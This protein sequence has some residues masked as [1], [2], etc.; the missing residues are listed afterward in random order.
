MHLYEPDVEKAISAIEAM[1][2]AYPDKTLWLTEFGPY[3]GGPSGCHFDQAGVVNYA[4]TVIPRINAL[5]YVEK[6]F[7]NCGDAEAASE[8]NPSLTNEDGSAN[9]VLKGLG[10]ACG[11]Y[12]T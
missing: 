4:K 12:V 2:A 8:C 1:H 9:D 6:V 3:N 7:W 5:G 11:F 10:G